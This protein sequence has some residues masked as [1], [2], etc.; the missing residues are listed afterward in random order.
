MLRVYYLDIKVYK[1]A[2]D[3]NASKDALV[4]IFER[5]ENLF[6]RLEI[7]TEVPPTDAMKELI[8][9]IMVQVLEILAVA[10]K[11]IK[12]R[13]SSELVV[14]HIW[15]LTHT[16]AERFM[17]KLMGRTDIEDALDKLD[18]LTHEEALMAG[19]EA[20]KLGMSIAK[21]MDRV[22][23]GTQHVSDSS[24]SLCSGFWG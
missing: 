21:K 6:K 2:K 15:R 18:K 20:M 17:K 9:R 11:E 1:A 10:T 24:Q 8:V 14:V 7:Y 23:D 5:I 4:D 12:Q 13:F 16:H 22:I 3:V 19:A